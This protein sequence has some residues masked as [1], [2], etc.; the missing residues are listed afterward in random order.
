[1][2]CE[3]CKFYETIGDA[4]G[5]CH[6]Y[7]PVP[8]GKGQNTQDEFPQVRPKDWCGESKGKQQ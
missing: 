2:N 5:L 8:D 3:D 1:M 7:P 4:S 6:R